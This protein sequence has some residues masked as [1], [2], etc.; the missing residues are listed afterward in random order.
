VKRDG[1]ITII[2]PLFEYKFCALVYL[3]AK[4]KGYKFKLASNKSDLGAFDDLEVGFLDGNNC[5]KRH[6][7]VQLKS[8]LNKHITMS[9][10]KSKNGDFSLRKYYDSYIEIEQNFNCSAEVKMDGS[11]DESLFI[12]YTNTDVAR[13]LKTNKVT[14]IGEEEFLMTGGSVLQFNEKEHKAIYEHLQDLPKHR[15]FLS[16]LRIFYSQANA[17]EMDWYIK[18][19]L[20]QNMKLPK[21]KLELAYMC[22]IDFVKDWWQN[23]NYFL[24]ETNSKENDV[25]EKTKEKVGTILIPNILDQRKSELD[26]LRIKYKQPAIR[27]IQK[28]IE[29]NR[30]V[31][32]FAPG[33]STTLTAAKIHQMLSDTE[34]II[35]NL[36]QLIRYKTEVMLAWK[37]RFDVL[38]LECQSSSENLEDVF[39]EISKTLNDFGVGKKLIFIADAMGN[40]EQI[41]ALRRT[42]STQLT[43]E[44][45]DWKFTDIITES[46]TFFLEK[47]IV[48][49]GFELQ[50]KDIVKESDIQMLNALDGDS[51][52]L[53]LADEKPSI[54]TPIEETLGLYIDRALE[55]TQNVK[56]DDFGNVY[57]DLERKPTGVWRPST[58]LEGENRVVLVIDEPGMGKSTLLTHLARETRQRHPD[59]WI[60]RVNI[61]NYT[62][63]LQEYKTKSFDENGA[64]KLLTEAANIKESD[65]MQLEKHLFNYVYNSTGNMAVLIDGVDEVCPYYAE[66]VLQFLRILSKTKIRKIWITSRNFMKDQLQQEFQCQPYSLLPFSV[67]DQKTFLLKFWNQEGDYVKD[68]AERVVELSREYLSDRDKSFMGVPLQGM[69][70]AEMFKENLKQCSTKREMK[71]PEYINLDILYD[72]YLNKKW[73]I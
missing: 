38:V 17:M 54:C 52:S 28:L 53:L 37:S 41:S 33:R 70:M 14:D 69:L 15:E 29:P 2:G 31:L 50:I 19:E 36:K 57:R 7:F 48:F 25:L 62:S 56:P 40:K 4:N 22:F 32:I 45:G 43:E 3:R 46:K 65:S 60:V 51:M 8:K 64:F 59:V 20:Q 18:S 61:N 55:C 9:Q 24:K 68:L 11:I 35:L 67:E 27:D 42:L 66:E 1:T 10:L 49:Q 39:N 5:S 12:I 72:S 44:Y 71:L 16:R 26:D 63:I 23:C 34:H 21:S 58:L 73:D 30:A 47:K 6:I 13:D